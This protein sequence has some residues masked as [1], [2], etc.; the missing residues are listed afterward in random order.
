[1]YKKQ[2]NRMET[3]AIGSGNYTHTRTTIS[4]SAKIKF[5]CYY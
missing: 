4:L 5:K 1:M 2:S 3:D